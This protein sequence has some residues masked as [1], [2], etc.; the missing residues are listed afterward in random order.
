M[1]FGS[2]LDSISRDNEEPTTISH[3]NP[4]HHNK[5]DIANRLSEIFGA[6]PVHSTT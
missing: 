3:I 4:D 6:T 2:S 5:D 1:R